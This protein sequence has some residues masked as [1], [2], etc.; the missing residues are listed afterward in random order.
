MREKR[1]H[2]PS[3]LWDVDALRTRQS[4]KASAPRGMLAFIR[5]GGLTYSR[6][7]NFF[8]TIPHKQKSPANAEP[9]YI[10]QRTFVLCGLHNL[11]IKNRINEETKLKYFV[12]WTSF[13]SKKFPALGLWCG[14]V[15]FGWIFSV[16][17]RSL[18]KVRRAG[19]SGKRHQKALATS[20]GQLNT[21]LKLASRHIKLVV[22]SD[23]S[24]SAECVY[25]RHIPAPFGCGCEADTGRAIKP[26][27]LGGCSHSSEVEAWLVFSFFYS[28]SSQ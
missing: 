19:E 22:A 15:D 24:G 23:R 6:L 20:I 5:G 28:L 16:T 12:C 13:F 10:K 7:S 26:L 9:S 25:I 8:A 3:H 11:C 18:T 21:L 1:V 17:T 4:H 2:L 27:T 14:F